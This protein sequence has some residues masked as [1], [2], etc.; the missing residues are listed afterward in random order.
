MQ[1]TPSVIPVYILN[2][3]LNIQNLYIL[4]YGHRY[5]LV[6]LRE[7]SLQMCKDFCPHNIFT[8]DTCA[9]IKWDNLECY[10]F[11]HHVRQLNIPSM[12]YLLKSKHLCNNVLFH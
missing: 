10:P 12:H 8:K 1:N 11:N 9:R 3:K 5:S 2:A 6:I 4:L 7:T